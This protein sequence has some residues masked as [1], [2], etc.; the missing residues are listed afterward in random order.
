[1]TAIPQGSKVFISFGEIDCRPN[2]GFISATTKLNKPIEEVVIS[3]VTGYL[4]W[5]YEQTKTQKHSLY[6]LNVPAPMYDQKYSAKVN[7]DVANVVILFN[8]QIKKQIAQYGFNIIDVY[9][10]TFGQDRFSNSHFHIDEKH[11]GAKAIPE[12]EQQL[13][14]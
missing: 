14:S 8:A 7:A 4:E 13:N 5:F 11:L 9:R 12:I 2:E 3:T 1:M 10:F 6:I